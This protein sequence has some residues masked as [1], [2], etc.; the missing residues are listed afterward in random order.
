MASGVVHII[1]AGLAGLASAVALRR[2]GV[3]VVVYEAARFAGGRCRSYFEPSL[4]ISIDNGNHLVLSGNRAALDYLAT[5]GAADKLT[6]PGEATYCFAD[7]STGERWRLRINDGRLPWWICSAR[8]RV[9]GTRAADYLAGM[10]LLRAKPPHTVAG[11]LGTSGH[12]YARLWRPLLLAALNTDPLEASAQLAGAVLRETLARGGT[13]C[14][15]LIAGDGL[16]AAFVDPAIAWLKR[17]R[18]G[19]HF[20]RRVRTLLFD[21]ERLIALDFGEGQRLELAAQDCVVLAVPASAAR[22]L[23]PDLEAPTEF[24]AIV[25]AHFKVDPPPGS[26]RILGVVGGMSEWLFAFAGRLSV[27]ISAADR[28][29]DAPREQLARGIWHEVASL[30]GLAE[31]L[32]AWQIIKERRATFAGLPAQQQKRPPTR[33]RWPNLV[34]AGDWTATGLPATIEGAIRSGNRAAHDLLQRHAALRTA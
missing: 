32:P 4:G 7:L 3:G 22:T 6:G 16:A 23:V 15:P 28:L 21:A 12:A 9:P 26:A 18:V 5:I 30:T 33:T 13:A 2:S 27:T 20:D 10:R 14:R 24:R 11:V 1:G 29:L 31:E 25:N 8:R 17:A 19:V 34:L